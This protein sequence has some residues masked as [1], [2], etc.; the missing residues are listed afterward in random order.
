VGRLVAIEGIDGSGKGTQAGILREAFLAA[1]LR[2]QLFSFP[3][4][5]ETGFGAKIGDFLNGRFGN[6]DQVSP[7]LVSLLFAGDRFE[8]RE[9][10]RQAIA[11]N[12]VVLCDRYVASNIAHQGAKAGGA[13]RQEVIEW[14]Q[15]V[16]Y[17][18][19]ELPRPDR[20]LF[21]DLPVRQAMT[22][23]AKKQR[24]SYTDL[25]ADLQESD[26]HYLQQVHDVYCQLAAGE[27]GWIQIDC[28]DG[29]AVKPVEQV[30]AEIWRTLG[31]IA[32]N[33]QR[34]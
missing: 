22:L 9:L 21:L 30:A 1:G 29:E 14:I 25:A 18:L 2:C 12:D 10:L 5:K 3:R 7:F 23:I 17:Q 33:S 8:S 31:D 15:F 26:S 20:V 27:S 16:E 6:L 13:Q 28:L 19:F 34:I 4:Y 11:S 24:R 32:V